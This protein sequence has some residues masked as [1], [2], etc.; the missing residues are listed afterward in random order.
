MVCRWWLS[1]VCVRVRVNVTVSLCVGV[2]L[3]FLLQFTWKMFGES[4]NRSSFVR[5]L[6]NQVHLAAELGS[7][8]FWNLSFHASGRWVL[9]VWRGL[10]TAPTQ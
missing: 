4:N 10:D 1:E 3:L 6:H 9:H 8:Y 7:L 2:C 5:G